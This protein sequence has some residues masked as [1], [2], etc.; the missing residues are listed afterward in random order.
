MAIKI[1]GT[2][3]TASPGITGPD[4][5]T[6]LVYGTDE[7]Q[8]VTGGTTRATVD[9]SGNLGIGTTSP[10]D[11]LSLSGSGTILSVA[12]GPVIALA[13]TSNRT[14]KIAGPGT[15]ANAVIGTT[16]NHNLDFI[17]GNTVRATVDSSG[18]VGIN[19]TP[20]T[21]QL[22][23]NAGAAN[24]VASFESTDATA[25][26]VFKDNSGEAMVGGTGDAV[27]FY[28][29]SSATERARLDSSGRL[30]VGTSSSADQ[31]AKI[32]SATTAF[33]VFEGFQHG[34]NSVGAILRLA[35]SRGSIGSQ[36]LVSNN[37]QLGL[38][39]FLGS[40]GSNYRN[41]ALIKCEV[42]G[43]PGSN[44]MPGRLVFSTTADS[45]SSPTERLRISSSGNVGIGTAS[46]QSSLSVAGTT[47]NAPSTEG[48]HL[49]LTSNYAVM[50]LSGNTGGLIDFAEASVD[51]AGR[52]IYTHSTDVMQL[53]TAGTEKLRIQSGG[54]ISFNGDT[55]AANALDDYEEGT[56]TPAMYGST[57]Y[58][59]SSASGTYTKIGRLVSL[60]CKFTFSAVGSN[61]SAMNLDGLP[62]ACSN[63]IHVPGVV[64]EANTTGAVFVSQIVKNTSRLGVNSMDGVTGGSNKTFTTGDKYVLQTT[65]YV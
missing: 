29:S 39:S 15:V 11:K 14:L 57:G 42:D 53:Y 46:P 44:D 22:E 38:I 18:K 6:G 12:S 35:K 58:V 3:T 48:V 63:D 43:T 47:P 31:N 50:Q 54:G 49:G 37:D 24:T 65:Y 5:D 27:T 4:T 25:R 55:A 34:S 45:A 10:S 9:S 52:I 19:K 1:N 30:L 61:N 23:V 32:Q 33:E 36:G 7:V 56:W 17:T 21:Y 26:I 41:S 8:V 59:L 28:T 64:R 20:S 40:D 2:N 16:S 51:Y 13:D 62:F 60:H